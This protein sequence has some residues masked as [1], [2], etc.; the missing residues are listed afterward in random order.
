MIE[1]Y[2]LEPSQC[3][4]VGDKWIDPQTGISAGMRGALVKTGK[5]IG[6]ELNELSQRSGVPICSDLNEFVSKELA[7]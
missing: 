4:V 7:L 5:P 6:E 1:K 3:W 2:D